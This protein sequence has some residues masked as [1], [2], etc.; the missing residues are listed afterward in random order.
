MARRKRLTPPRSDYLD[1]TGSG[2]LAQGP[3][4]APPL[5][6]VA[7]EAASSAALEELSEEMT[8]ARA[9]G[10][11]IE[12]LPLDAVDAA[13]LVRDRIG[14]S[15]EEQSALID[16]LRNRGQQT[17]IEVVD[18]GAGR[19]GGRYGLI[20]GWRRLMALR[21]LHDETGDDRFSIVQARITRP[22]E[23]SEAYLAMVEENE[24]RVGLSHYE[25]AR[26]AVRAVE[27]GVFPHDRAALDALYSNVSRARKS[28]IRSFISLV[29]R[30]DDALR[31][32]AAI[33]ERLGL[34][35][36]RRLGEDRAF[37]R[38][39]SEALKRAD[40]K[41]EEA[42]HAVLKQSLNRGLETKPKRESGPGEKARRQ[43]PA[44][45]SGPGAGAP[46]HLRARFQKIHASLRDEEDREEPSLPGSDQDPHEVIMQQ[47]P[48]SREIRLS[49]PG[50]DADFVR[51]LAA[52][53]ESRSRS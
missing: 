29:R 14:V 27:E 52:W 22:G 18:L 40:P 21:H 44:A 43:A 15:D 7:G 5:A 32:P 31:F 36:A 24:I 48:D 39:V 6:Q 41:D 10:R 9:E 30:L 35:L 42:E 3:L 51:E 37:A 23:T 12:A 49:G 2:P 8:R 50:V 16:S 53:L 46:P 1:Q 26:I 28:K 45:P 47:S 20:S 13:Y 38:T 33:G 25:R 4:S 11:F 17:A 19:P 34:E